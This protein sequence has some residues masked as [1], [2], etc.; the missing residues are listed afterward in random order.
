ML[1]VIISFLRPLKL[2]FFPIPEVLLCPLF[3]LLMVK[4]DLGSGVGVDSWKNA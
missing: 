2:D 3:L 1:L 4:K